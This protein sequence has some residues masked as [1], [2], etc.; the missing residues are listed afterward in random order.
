M[1]EDR[2]FAMAVSFMEQ[3]ETHKTAHKG[4]MKK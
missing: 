3:F 1:F 4:W 2:I